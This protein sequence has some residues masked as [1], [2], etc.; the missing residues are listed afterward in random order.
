MKKAFLLWGL[1]AMI[2]KEG[3]D[4]GSSPCW[5]FRSI[6]ETMCDFPNQAF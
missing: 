6:E 3:V 4:L 2:D 5:I 1:L